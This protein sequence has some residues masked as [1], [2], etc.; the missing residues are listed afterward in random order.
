MKAEKSAD[1]ANSSTEDSEKKKK[2][3]KDKKEKKDKKEDGDEEMGMAGFTKFL[4]LNQKSLE[5]RIPSFEKGWKSTLIT[6]KSMERINDEDIAFDDMNIYLFSETPGE[7]VVIDLISSIYHSPLRVL[8]S[9]K[10]SI[11]KRQDF[12]LEGD[13]MIFD[14]RTQQGKFTGNVKMV[15]HDAAN[16]GAGSS[17]ESKKSEEAKTSS[18]KD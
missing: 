3:D 5:V 17:P 10:K 14:T 18:K 13:S 8:K 9:D 2:K 15:I 7:D 1:S 16:F 11:V 4:A 6:A 12:V